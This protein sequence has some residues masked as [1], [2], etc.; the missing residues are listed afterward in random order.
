[1]YYRFTIAQEEMFFNQRREKGKSLKMKKTLKQEGVQ[2]DVAKVP[3]LLQLEISLLL[4]NT[5]QVGV[6]GVE[7]AILLNLILLMKM[8]KLQAVAMEM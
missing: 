2:K 4:I 7:L 5:K 6:V 3:L 8:V 1:M